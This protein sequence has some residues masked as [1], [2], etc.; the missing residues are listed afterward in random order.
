MAIIYGS[1]GNDI[2]SGT[3]ANDTMYG[4]AGDDTLNGGAGN[5]TLYGGPGNDILD[6][7]FGIDTMVGGA[8]ND[9]YYVNNPAD[10]TKEE[11]STYGTFDSVF[12]T[13]TKHILG[14]WIENLWFSGTANA[15]GYGNIL[16]NKIIGN[17]GNDLFYGYGGN[18]WILGGNGN[19]TLYG[20]IGNDTLDGGNGNDY[21]YGQAGDDAMY[22]GNGNDTFGVNSLLDTVTE[23]SATGGYDTVNS[24][25]TFTLGANL[26][27][28]NLT[29]TAATNGL[30]NALDNSI[31]G[32]SMNNSLYGYGGNDYLFGND[33]NDYLSGSTGN[34]TLDGWNGT[35]SVV[36]GDGN[37]TLLGWYG[38][39]YLYGETGNDSLYG[40]GDNDY[41]S[42]GTGNDTLNGGF[43]NDTLFGGD[44]ADFFVFNTVLGSTNVDTITDFYWGEGDK[45]HLDKDIFTSLTYTGALSS[46]NFWKSNSGLSIDSN[47]YILYYTGSNSLYYDR[48]GSGGTYAPIKFATVNF[49]G[50]DDD[51]LARDFTVVA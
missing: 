30:G 50:A 51:I 31:S 22:G 42:G 29:G 37:D 19:D 9:I 33:G 36:G 18:D 48:D 24:T 8:G 11:F 15:T 35:D 38:N 3:A 21:L 45:I 23:D 17:A 44:N 49:D 14:D 28:L 5:D 1:A 32:N 12:T 7:G 4:Y 10:V 41:L 27:K 2:L 16:N 6:G 43:G 46:T 25:V 34:D 26:E 39:D 20:S 13:T 40:E 47:D